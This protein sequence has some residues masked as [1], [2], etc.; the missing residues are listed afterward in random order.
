MKQ[1]CD[2]IDCTVLTNFLLL[3]DLDEEYVD[4]G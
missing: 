3:A 2:L 4:A 1:Q